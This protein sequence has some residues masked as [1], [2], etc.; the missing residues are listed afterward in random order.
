MILRRRGLGLKMSL[1]YV[2]AAAAAGALVSFGPT[3]LTDINI[4]D[5]PYFAILG[6]HGIWGILV[7]AFSRRFSRRRLRRSAFVPEVLLVVSLL[8]FLFAYMY[9]ANAELDYVERFVE[10]GELRFSLDT[11]TERAIS[12]A[13]FAPFFIVNVFW[14]L[15]LRIRRRRLTERSWPAAAAADPHE[16]APAGAREQGGGSAPAA[17]RLAPWSLVLTLVSIVFVTLSFPSFAV[18]EGLPWLA[19]IGLVPLFVAFRVTGYRRAV[20]Y[21]VFFG[22][23]VTLLSNF[24][25]ATFNLL[26]LQFTVVLYLLFYAIFMPIAVATLKYVRRGAVLVMPFAF[27]VFELARSSGFLG[28]PWNLLGHSQYT[29]LPLIQTAAVTGVWGIT[30]LIVLVNSALA[31]ALWAHLSRRVPIRRALRTPAAA[32]V[33]VL[34]IAAAGAVSLRASAPGEETGPGT[35]SEARNGRGASVDAR[36]ARVALIQQNSDPRKHDYRDTFNS[37]K[38]L[39]DLSLAHDPDLVAWA[40]TAFVPNIRRWEE[41]DSSRWLHRL[42]NDFLEYQES[43]DTWL[44]T[45]NDDYEVIRNEDGDEVDRHSFNAAVLFSETGER[46]E[47]YHKMRLVPFTE[48]F[49]YED[50]FPRVAQ[51]MRD[52]DVY[53]W[54]EGEERT[55]FEHPEFT[56]STPICFED[57]FPGEVREFVRAG[58]E[59]I[60]NITNDYWSLTEVQGQ[61]HFAGGMFRAVENRR[62]V[63]R[64]TTSGLTAHVDPYGRVGNTLPYYE[65]AY[66]IVELQIPEE[67]STTLY[68]RFG[69]WFVAVC[70]AGLLVLVAAETARRYRSGLAGAARARRA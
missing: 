68:T 31:E 56:F 14:Y 35:D 45:G 1:S 8:F 47:T 10:G 59:V 25:L 67:Q 29:R 69:D 24:W 64:A 39:T 7:L 54:E 49:P 33:V 4:Y 3:A 15:V 20:F 42:V 48:H 65:E 34:A 36:T 16:A 37:L 22:T 57:K 40:E 46:V 6:A 58:A 11:T 12:L 2:P 51:L 55:V 61:Q 32:V 27:T 30:F 38:R 17:T 41:D 63:L 19:W 62:P 26:S 5:I 9:A 44:L 18:L 13:R 52:F 43:I 60:L 23:A 21:G 53:H 28:Y 66:T 50:T 70:A